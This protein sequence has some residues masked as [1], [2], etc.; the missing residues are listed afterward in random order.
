MKKRLFLGL[1]VFNLIFYLS[2]KSNWSGIEAMIG[3]SWLQYLIFMILF[4]IFIYEGV[5]FLFINKKTSL[6]IKVCQ[7]I[8]FGLLWFMFYMGI[9]SLRYIFRSFIE[10]LGGFMVLAFF[11]YLI[12]Y[13][14][15]Q[16]KSIQLIVRKITIIVFG[17]GFLVFAFFS[18]YAMLST[19]PTVYAVENN[20]QIVWTTSIPASGEVIIGDK[21]YYDLYA[22]SIDSFTTVHKVVVPM[23][24]L[25]QAKQYNIQ[26]T[27]YIYRGPYS[28]LEGRTIS[29][30][31]NFRPVDLSDGLQYYSL[32]DTHEYYQAASKTGTYF[33]ED[34]D[35]LVLIGDIA[36]HL[37]RE[38]DIEIILKI[39]NRITKGERPVVYARG[40][41][42]TKGKYANRLYQYV[43]SLNESFFYTFEMQGIFGIVLDL[44]EDH[45][46]N[47]WEY[48]NTAHFDLYR[49]TQTAFIEDVI[50]QN[51][52]NNEDVLYR[53]GICHMPV[54]FVNNDYSPYNENDL[55]LAELKEEWTGLLN[56][57][58]LNVML[59]GH[60]H[61][62]YQFDGTYNPYETLYYNSLYA[63]NTE[64]KRGYMTDSNFPL[65]T[66]SRRSNEPTYAKAENLFGKALIGLSTFV[67][68]DQNIQTLIYT[69]TFHETVEIINA[70]NGESTLQ[71]QYD[72]D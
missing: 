23:E 46:D 42:E 41:H 60:T 71:F 64:T 58:N 16:T 19:L 34:L 11:I 55:F 69:N 36:S 50:T 70:F 13:Y 4:I 8:L 17:V 59:S 65:F 31:Y 40:N 18:S 3:P 53:M 29:K 22:G 63:A 20:Y 32:S 44:G 45:K 68:F 27:S 43:G 52:Y 7:L 21:T 6:W 28:G 51:Q 9:G 24:E 33:E 30:Q 5:L 26:S 14:P 56:Q 57:L 10:Y 72:L 67:D 66:V 61:K 25:D 12:R 35:F 2:Q 62:L 54:T 49:A 1:S 37:E 15:L 38:S 47:W 39:A 48:Y